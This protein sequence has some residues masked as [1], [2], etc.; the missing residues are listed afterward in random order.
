M[1][2]F[3]VGDRVRF[4]RDNGKYPEGYE[5]VVHDLD[6]DG[7]PMIRHPDGSGD[8]WFAHALSETTTLVSRAPEIY[9]SPTL[10]D[11]FAMSALTGLLAD[12]KVNTDGYDSPREFMGDVA[13]C[14]Y[15]HARAMMK[16]RPQ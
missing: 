15:D 16:A 11:Q 13:M 8:V 12:P 14:A 9:E 10:L 2:K 4:T 3:K 6:G 1:G 5:V 7:D